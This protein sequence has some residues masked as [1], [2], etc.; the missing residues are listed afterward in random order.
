MK[1][2]L[3]TLFLCLLSL[4]CFSEANFVYHEATTNTIGPNP[5]RFRDL[6]TPDRTQSVNVA[7]KIEWQFYWT[8]AVIYYTTDGSNP[9]GAFGVGS[10]T[11]Q[12]VNALF[13]YNFGSPLVDVVVGTIPAQPAGTTVKYIVSAWF[14]GGGDEIFGNGCGN[15]PNPFCTTENRP[16]SNATVFQYTVLRTSRKIFTLD[17]NPNVNLSGS[18]GSCATPGTTTPNVFNI[19]V[20]GVGTMSATNQLTLASIC[21]NDCGTGTKNFNAIQIRVMAPNGQC[22]GVYSGGL[23]TNGSGT[24]CLNL[25]SNNPCLN[26]PNTFNEPSTGSPLTSSGNN[27]YY[28]AQYCISG[29]CPGPTN[30]SNFTGSADGTWKIIFSESTSNPPCVDVIRLFF[31]DPNY[32]DAPTGGDN[33]SNPIV[34]DG[35]SQICATTAGKTGSTQMPGS[36]NGPNTNTFGTIS[37][38]TCGWNFANNNEV[39]IKYTATKTTTCLS[40]S[41]ISGTNV[42]LQSIVVTDANTNDT[43]PCTQIPRTPTND[44]NWQIVSCPRPSI[45]GTTAGTQYN[46]QH[47]FTSEIGKTYYLVVDGDGGANSKFFI[48]GFDFNGVLLFDDVKNTAIVRDNSFSVNNVNGVLITKNSKPHKQTV[49]IYDMSGMLLYKNE[50]FVKKD[51]ALDLNLYYKPGVNLIR[52]IVDDNVQSFVFKHLK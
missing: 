19:S 31:G 12:V 1:R 39:W 30:Y 2:A 23:T 36:I 6:L 33:C 4:S 15:A 46:Q 44:P 32:T 9:S 48:W 47:C 7:F 35:T 13:N 34:W 8:N 45:Y 17:P 40:V 37:G 42:S 52:V 49:I 38:Q 28:N 20:S 25:V 51:N 18:N 26:N 3:K 21:L 43:D 50:V 14:A 11:T 10:G 16:A 24:H 27:G 41:G 22:F 5:L 29:S